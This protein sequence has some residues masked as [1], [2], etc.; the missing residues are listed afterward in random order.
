MQKVAH[1]MQEIVHNMQC[2]SV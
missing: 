2:W 1:N